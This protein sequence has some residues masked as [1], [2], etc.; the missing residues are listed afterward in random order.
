MSP[1]NVGA[2][3]NKKYVSIEGP[4]RVSS[5]D[6]STTFFSTSGAQ[7]LEISQH[8]NAVKFCTPEELTY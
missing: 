4:F 2:D 3:L 1:K 5:V 6:S 8:L 7:N